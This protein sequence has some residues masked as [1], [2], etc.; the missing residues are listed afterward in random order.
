MGSASIDRRER[1]T[2]TIKAIRAVAATL[3]AVLA[4]VVMTLGMFGGTPAYAANAMSAVATN[5]S[6][7]V[8][9]ASQ[10]MRIGVSV[11]RYDQ[12]GD[13]QYAIVVTNNDPTKTATAIKGSTTIPADIAESGKLTTVDWT[14]GDLAPG[15]HAYALVDGQTLTV[16]LAESSGTTDDGNTGTNDGTNT[17][18]GNTNTSTGTTTPGNNADNGSGNNASTNPNSSATDSSNTDSASKTPANKTPSGNVSADTN[19]AKSPD[20]LSRT[21]VSIAGIT[22]FALLLLAAAGLIVGRRNAVAARQT[23]VSGTTAGTTNTGTTAHMSGHAHLGTDRIHSGPRLSARALI[24]ASVAIA[25]L[26]AGLM[27]V[28]NALAAEPGSE[29]TAEP[30]ANPAGENASVDVISVVTVNN[31]GYEINSHVTATFVEPKKETVAVVGQAQDAG[32]QPV[33]NAQLN[34]TATGEQPVTVTTDADGYFVAHLTRNVRYDAVVRDTAAVP[35]GQA[36]PQ[37]VKATLLAKQRNDITVQNVTGAITLGRKVVEGTASGQIK[38]SAIYLDAKDYRIS[39]DQKTVTVTDKT[40]DVIAGDIVVLAPNGDFD[41]KVIKVAAVGKTGTGADANLTVTGG[42]ADLPDA[43]DRISLD[44]TVLDASK[45]EVTPA[46]GVTAKNLAEPAG[47]TRMRGAKIGVGAEV[48]QSLNYEFDYAKDLQ[49][50]RK[51]TAAKP[52]L[53]KVGYVVNKTTLASN[54]TAKATVDFVHYEQSNVTLEAKTEFN[55]AGVVCASYAKENGVNHV[56]YSET[57][58]AG[59]EKADK[60]DPSGES[61]AKDDAAAKDSAKAKAAKTDSAKPGS[62]G[63]TDSTDSATDQE[64]EG[65]KLTK[66]PIAW[67]LPWGFKVE[68]DATLV[69]HSSG[70]FR[71]TMKV[72]A[73]AEAKAVLQNGKVTATTKASVDPNMELTA[74]AKYEV[75][76]LMDPTLK[77]LGQGIVTLKGEPGIGM[78]VQGHVKVENG[79]L[80]P[81][82]ASAS[83]E[84]YGY[85]N[86]WY[87]FPI[88]EPLGKL[89]ESNP[90]HD[91]GKYAEDQ[92]FKENPV[93]RI[94]LDKHEASNGPKQQLAKVRKQIAAG[95]FSSIAGK[96]CQKD[97]LSCVSIDD[98]G[99]FRQVSGTVERAFAPLL[100][101]GVS[102]LGTGDDSLNAWEKDVSVTLSG[103]VSEY[104]CALPNGTTVNGEACKALG[105]ENITRWPTGVA[106]YPAGWESKDVY[107]ETNGSY[108]LLDGSKEV[109][110]S[111]PF[112]QPLGDQYVFAPQDNVD[113][114]PLSGGLQASNGVYY[115]VK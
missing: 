106:Y 65:I 16:K 39:A 61:G 71:G 89:P 94:T 14:V 18:N 107:P 45:A 109:D 87:A 57:E 58:C 114:Y 48:G 1:G 41:G 2:T 59:T 34:L 46:D 4:A 24:A 26:G 86:E 74:A 37:I 90:L 95:D 42:D 13:D 67:R 83:W 76:L 27:I 29:S 105:R 97:G 102:Q 28:P 101:G 50:S 111:T 30:T 35:E 103:S 43:F 79:K 115:L 66:K 69:S 52:E 11:E 93:A 36:A 80:K 92:E 64:F 70:H 110:T 108:P 49:V 56:D 6:S 22:G 23:G 68:T 77:A 72:K 8:S 55:T 113:R 88:L 73:S 84:L 54:I 78:E 99:R 96:Y 100:N 3:F 12:A 51:T 40:I 82:D 31:H 38:S 32:R 62:S 19:T 21:G 75:G 25:M 5:V 10:I 15:D 47:K 85:S 98:K 17:S 7:N 20:K 63:S 112:L 44:N 104:Q 81:G 60:K 53:A 9:T 33:K 91:L